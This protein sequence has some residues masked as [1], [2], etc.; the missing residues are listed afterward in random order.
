M[1]QMRGEAAVLIVAHRLAT[2]KAADRVIVLAGGEIVESGRHEELLA[3][4]GAYWTLARGQVV[5]E[6]QLI[7]GIA[8]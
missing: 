1:L 2:V 8:S 3:K 6:E 5:A 7:S 4:R